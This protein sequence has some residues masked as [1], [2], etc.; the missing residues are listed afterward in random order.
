MTPQNTMS[1]YDLL[2]RAIEQ[3]RAQQQNG[4]DWNSPSLV[5]GQNP[6]G[7]QAPQG[8]LGRLRTLLAEQSQYQP[9]AGSDGAAPVQP[10]DPNFRQLSRAPSAS[11]PQVAV[12]ASNRSTAQSGATYS[13]A[14]G[15]PSLDFR[16]A[17]RQVAAP[18][19]AAAGLFG[20]K[21][22]APSWTVTPSSMTPIPVG[23]RLGGVPVPWPGT[24]LPPPPITAPTIPEAWK[25]AWKIL[26][27]YPAIASGRGGGGG[28]YDRC[29]RAVDGST[30][31]WEEFCKSLVFGKN[32]TSGGE[33][34]NRACWSKTYESPNNKKE[35][36]ENQFGAH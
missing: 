4:D 35:W 8:L 22:P 21:T 32:K 36:C 28:A 17:T 19:Q 33:S 1:A 24:T 15:D 27:L 9:A 12:G 6:D 10:L 7:D 34:Q 29:I 31:Q 5:P 14:S 23:W 2:R 26:Q 20:S 18:P 13:P 3:Q 16:I 25:T 11:R 30:E